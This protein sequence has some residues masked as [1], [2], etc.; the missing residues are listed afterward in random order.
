M[1]GGVEKWVAQSPQPTA[2]NHVAPV[3][4][5][6]SIADRF[7]HNGFITQ[8]GAS[9]YCGDAHSI[10]GFVPQERR[11]STLSDSD[12]VSLLSTSARRRWITSAA[13]FASRIAR[14]RNRAQ[15]RPIEGRLLRER[16]SADGED[17]TT[18]ALVR[19]AGFDFVFSNC[20]I[21]RISR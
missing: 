4:C 16:A 7:A 8:S 17:A 20:R 5:K 13:G 15:N 19:E 2:D 18:D 21:Q 6:T 3:G 14:P 12:C 1:V 10:A 11:P 9:A